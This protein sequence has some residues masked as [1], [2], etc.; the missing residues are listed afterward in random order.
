MRQ[1]NRLICAGLAMFAVVLTT[2]GLVEA[3]NKD[4]ANLKPGAV[5]KECRNCPDMVV[6]PAGKFV[7]GTP[8][9]QEMHE[10]DE[11]QHE[12]TIAKPFALS[13]TEVTWDQ[14]EAC[15][16]DNACDGA[17]VDVAL[18]LDRDGKPDPN[19]KDWGRG[20][21]PVVGVSWYD[22]QHYVGWLNRKTGNDDAY[23]LASEAEW[24]Y[25]ARAGTT[26]IYGWGDKLD[27]N[28]GNF[29]QDGHELG[30]MAQGRDVWENETAPVGSFP[31]NA[32][33]LYD[34]FGNAFEWIEDCYL[35]DLRKGPSDGS[36]NKNGSCNS[37]EFRS[38]SFISNP[39]MHRAGNRVPGY[40]PT[41]RGRNY[42][43][44][45]VAKTLE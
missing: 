34:M 32:F 29:G 8:E 23:R 45:R 20:N 43:S 38:G 9:D 33:G 28:Y 11:Y 4:A 37:R 16:R 42:L 40:V 27:H 17:A 14:W 36:A 24:E 5:F 31:P 10:K 1:M 44:I 19:Y 13:K 35:E 12:V 18:R 3:A 7:M 2:P 39:H 41:T 6:I 30:P 22:A 25:A 15:V 21:R 26:T